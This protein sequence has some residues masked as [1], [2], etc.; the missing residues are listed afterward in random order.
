M[1]IRING[2]EIKCLDGKW[3]EFDSGKEY[4]DKT[5]RYCDDLDIFGQN[6]LYQYLNRTSTRKGSDVLSE[7]LTTEPGSTGA[8]ELRQ[9]IIT[10]L[11]DR[12]DFRQQFTARGR[13]I[14]EKEGDLEDIGTWLS[15]DAYITKHRW[16]FYLA[17][18]ISGIAL[19]IITSGFFNNSNFSIQFRL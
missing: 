2:D 6:S 16:L 14:Q 7:Q 1:L 15:R 11:K 8:V 12:V 13:L 3:T 17:L 5:H 4:Y 19:A 18:A 9:G 10:D